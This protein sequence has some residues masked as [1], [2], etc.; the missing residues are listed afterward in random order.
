MLDHRKRL[1]MKILSKIILIGLFFDLVDELDQ[2]KIELQAANEQLAEKRL[3]VETLRY[4]LRQANSKTSDW[5]TLAFNVS[6]R[7]QEVLV[8]NQQVKKEIDSLRQRYEAQA[9]ID[10]ANDK[11]AILTQDFGLCQAV[12]VELNRAVKTLESSLVETNAKYDEC[13]S[14]SEQYRNSMSQLEFENSNLNKELTE[15]KFKLSE[16]R[17]SGKIS[18]SDLQRSAMFVS[19]LSES[20]KQNVVQVA[21]DAVSETT[22]LPA[23]ARHISQYLY[24]ELGHHHWS[25]VVTDRV[26]DLSFV[27]DIPSTASLIFSVQGITV[28]LIGPLKNA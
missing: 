24:S 17:D 6:N 1:N 16:D 20:T 3:D 13:K 10:E 26:H 5:R 2:V 21:R 12:N 28:I 14:L 22:E 8:E 4:D 25:C 18:L 19:T 23:V 7:L 27:S 11:V 9:L 15:T